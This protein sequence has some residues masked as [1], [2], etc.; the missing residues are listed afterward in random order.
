MNTFSD[1]EPEIVNENAGTMI[2]G[3]N[4]TPDIGQCLEGW[5]LTQVCRDQ[6]NP[7]RVLRLSRVEVDQTNQRARASIAFIVVQW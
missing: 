5:F 4:M 2:A 7:Y 1:V 6:S 3:G